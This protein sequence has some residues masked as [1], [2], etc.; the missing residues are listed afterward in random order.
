MARLGE[1]ELHCDLTNDLV[2][3]TGEFLFACYEVVLVSHSEHR[4]DSRGVHVYECHVCVV[5]VSVCV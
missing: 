5:C 1:E 4:S 2:P 3:H